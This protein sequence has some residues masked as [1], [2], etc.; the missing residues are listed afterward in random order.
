MDNQILF[1]DLLENIDNTLI[2]LSLSLSLSH[3]LNAPSYEIKYLDLI[4][5]LI[6][7]V[8]FFGIVYNFFI[9]LLTRIVVELFDYV[10]A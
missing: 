4:S 6:F 2:S 1:Y 10:H 9:Y 5:L 8:L 3:K 7:S